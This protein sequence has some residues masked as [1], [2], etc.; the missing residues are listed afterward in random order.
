M[1]RVVFYRAIVGADADQALK[2]WMC[3]ETGALRLLEGHPELLD[4]EVRGRMR[5]QA[6][7]SFSV[8]RWFAQLVPDL[9]DEREMDEA[10]LRSAQGEDWWDEVPHYPPACREPLLGRFSEALAHHDDKRIEALAGW[11]EK[12][13]VDETTLIG[14]FLT[15]IDALEHLAD[16]DLSGGLRWCAGRLSTGSSWDRHGQAIARKVLDTKRPELLLALCREMAGMAIGA[17]TVLRVPVAAMHEALAR[18]LIERIECALRQE[19]A[20]GEE[21][22]K[23]LL[24]ALFFLNP[25][26]GLSGPFSKVRRLGGGAALEELLR[27]CGD[28]LRRNNSK[29]ATVGDLRMAI[30]E[31]VPQQTGEA[32]ASE[33]ASA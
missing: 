27:V 20:W 33:G 31:L 29:E 7:A 4:D 16:L 19:D 18:V 11:L 28:H 2:D 22:A 17:G 9:L 14:V 10:A 15:R 13:G 25:R 30:S 3:R 8:A 32:A 6:L 5:A 12:N 26:S 21:E 23:R 24:R 1:D